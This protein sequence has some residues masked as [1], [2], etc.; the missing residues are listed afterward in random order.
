MRK[1]K[2]RSIL[3]LNEFPASPIIRGEVALA[4]CILNMCFPTRTKH[5][6]GQKDPM[7]SEEE[8]GVPTACEQ[9]RTLG[10]GQSKKSI[11][12]AQSKHYTNRSKYITHAQGNRWHQ[13]VAYHLGHAIIITSPSR[14]FY[15]TWRKAW[16]RRNV[17]SLGWSIPP[18]SFKNHWVLDLILPQ[19]TAARPGHQ[20][21]SSSTSSSHS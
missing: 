14:Q 21:G 17:L 10:K 18:L 1:I 7:D 9:F 4:Q 8:P 13:I 2:S 19:N 15:S 20:P 6:Q 16:H 12:C 5:I 11:N 3:V